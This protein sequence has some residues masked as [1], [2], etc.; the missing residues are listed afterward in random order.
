MDISNIR[1]GLRIFRSLRGQTMRSCP[2]CGYA[3]QFVAFGMP[4]RFDAQCP[5]CSSLERH[6]LFVHH[7]TVGN[8]FTKSH[9]VLHFAPEPVIRRFLSEHAGEYI[10]ADLSG[11]N[12]D[13]V[14][15]IESVTFED[16]RFDAVIASHVLEHVND[17]L[18]LREI[19]R[20]LKPNGKVYCMVPIVEGW[21]TTYE[22]PAI[23]SERDRIVHFGQNDHVRFYGADFRRRIADARFA[24]D[25]YGADGQQSVTLSLHRGEKVF[26]GTR[27]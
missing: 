13:V 23:Q 3:G 5:K 14:Q 11:R 2:C 12:V 18:A 15:N 20:V 22:N 9:S 6:R 25:E 1:Y 19:H 10:S 24:V 26:V 16:G 27:S 17:V 7:A 21:S 8:W 4:P